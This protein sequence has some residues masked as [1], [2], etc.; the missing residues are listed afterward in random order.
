MNLFKKIKKYFNTPPTPFQYIAGKMED[1]SNLTEN[2]Y[3]KQYGYWSKCEYVFAK[4]IIM[5]MILFKRKYIVEYK[6]ESVYKLEVIDFMNVFLDCRVHTFNE[7]EPK[8][9]CILN[10]IYLMNLTLKKSD[11]L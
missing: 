8:R 5:N 9:I 1:Y 10:D 3:I 2:C 11:E 4:P 6:Y 7:S